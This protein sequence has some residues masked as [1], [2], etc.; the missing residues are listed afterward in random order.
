VAAEIGVSGV[1]AWKPIFAS[2][3]MTNVVLAPYRSAMLLTLF[4]PDPS[5]E[6][7][8]H[9]T[10][11]FVLS[12]AARGRARIRQSRSRSGRVVRSGPSEPSCGRRSNQRLASPLYGDPSEL[13]IVHEPLLPL[14]EHTPLVHP[15]DARPLGSGAALGPQINEKRRLTLEDVERRFR[16]SAAVIDDFAR[17]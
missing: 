16:R 2:A 15:R 6:H 8:F 4:M 11:T 9:G 1:A 12:V 7:L 17:T 14:R 10:S 5:Y 3:W 13:P